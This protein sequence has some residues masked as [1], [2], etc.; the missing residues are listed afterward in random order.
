M[1]F[2][3]RILCYHAVE[4]AFSRPFA[5][6]LKFL[7]SK[8]YRFCALSDA[9][10][11]NFSSGKYITITFDDGDSSIC[12]VAQPILDSMG[13][14]AILYLTTDYLLR[15]RNYHVSKSN[16]AVDWEQLGY[17]LEAGHEIGS[18]THTHANMPSCSHNQRVKELELSRTT[19]ERELGV[20]PT[21]FS[22]PWGQHDRETR[23]LLAGTGKWRSAATIDRGWNRPGSDA[24]LLKRDVVEPYWSHNRIRFHFLLGGFPPLYRFQ[25]FL[26][27]LISTGK[28]MKG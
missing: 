21:H 19:I 18:H 8:G 27:G 10:N 28:L 7:T 15:G 4:G 22:Y 6:Q 14:K 2:L 13:I 3:W 26:R 12:E 17:W 11:G 9:L 20:T 1:A 24:F 16:R 5:S 25:R 23:A